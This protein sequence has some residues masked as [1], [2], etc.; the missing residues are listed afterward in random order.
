MYIVYLF[1]YT[2]QSDEVQIMPSTK[3]LKSPR[4]TAIKV[5][6]FLS[7]RVVLSDI[8]ALRQP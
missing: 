1:S 7:F 5:M 2:G 8:V 3:I 4:R 6:L